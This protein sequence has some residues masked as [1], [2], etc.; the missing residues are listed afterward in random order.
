MI[1]GQ[2]PQENTRLPQAAASHAGLCRRRL[3]LHS[4]PLPPPGLSEPE[5]PNQLLL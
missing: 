5:A 4:V 3:T 1:Q 2:L